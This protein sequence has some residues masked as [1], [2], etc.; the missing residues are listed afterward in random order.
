MPKW[1]P[2]GMSRDTI[3]EQ[4]GDC[5]LR[6]I[7]G[8]YIDDTIESVVGTNDDHALSLDHIREQ[9]R[10]KTSHDLHHF[11]NLITMHRHCNRVRSDTPFVQFL[12]RD[13]A[14][15]VAELFPRVAPTILALLGG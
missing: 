1:R 5:F 12:G 4:D 6:A 8:C 10:N 14:R 3:R 15:M 11:T 7:G 2:I 13:R 9:C